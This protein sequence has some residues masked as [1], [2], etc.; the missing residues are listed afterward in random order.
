[1]SLGIKRQT[2]FEYRRCINDAIDFIHV[3]FNRSISIE[4]VAGAAGFSPYH[5]H[6]IFSAFVGETIG[7]YI[8]RIRLEKGL[9][10]MRNHSF[11][12]TDTSIEVGFESSS[13]F[14][15]S[16]RQFYGISPSHA[17]VTE[18]APQPK[19]ITI[20]Q[21]ERKK[22]M[23]VRFVLKS[24]QK[25]IF[26]EAKGKENNDYTKAAD[27]AF[28]KICSYLNQQ[29]LWNQVDTC[30]S[31]SPDESGKVP[32]EE[33]RYLGGFTL[34]PGTSVKAANGIAT[35]V[36]P[37][38]K[39]AVFRHKGPYETLWQSWKAIYRYWLP[40]SEVELRDVEPYEVYLDDKSNTKPEDLRTDIYIAIK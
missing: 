5:F 3:N 19:K 37:G 21:I 30:L 4:D 29:K 2:E 36:I 10:L 34:K 14:S 18:V 22:D 7:D 24:D 26:A 31:M 27:I 1:M 15:K 25:F 11:S 23:D 12:V 8:R 17:K 40:T 9:H 35:M 16:F 13:S 28:D 32:D 38:G 33:C 20:K 6:R 39:Y